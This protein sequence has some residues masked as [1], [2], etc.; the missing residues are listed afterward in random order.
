MNI[1]SL[2][3]KIVH[4]EKQ[5]VIKIGIFAIIK[6]KIKNYTSLKVKLI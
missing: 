1:Y 5:A 4:L 3:G 6:H 2:K